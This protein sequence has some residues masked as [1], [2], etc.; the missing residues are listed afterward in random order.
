MKSRLTGYY[1][2]WYTGDDRNAKVVKYWCLDARYFY[3]LSIFNEAFKPFTWSFGRAHSESLSYLKKNTVCRTKV[4][5]TSYS[6]FYYCSSKMKTNKKC[7]RQIVLTFLI[8]FDDIDSLTQFLRAASSWHTGHVVH[9]SQ[10]VHLS[11]VTWLLYVLS[12]CNT[13][14]P[15][16]PPWLLLLYGCCCW[17]QKKLSLQVFFKEIFLYI[18]ETSTSS[19]DHKWMVIQTLTRICAGLLLCFQFFKALKL[20]RAF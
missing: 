3:L 19:Y 10:C 8:V 6:T 2:V 14:A 4:T 15:F 17:L 13:W 9:C 18:L 20:M 11:Q 12:V 7:K 1:V 5:L 16:F